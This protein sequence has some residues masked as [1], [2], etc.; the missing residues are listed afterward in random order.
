MTDQENPVTVNLK[1]PGWLQ[2]VVR[3]V[4]SRRP[5]FQN[6]QFVSTAREGL[7]AWKN[8]IDEGIPGED[9][10][11]AS[12]APA[13]LTFTDWP[14]RL[15]EVLALA[16]E[17]PDYSIVLGACEDGLP[18]TLDLT[19]P[20]PGSLLICGGAG[21]GMTHLLQSILVSATRLNPAYR[22]AFNLLAS[23]PGE[24]QGLGELDACQ[25][26]LPADGDAS[27]EVILELTDIAEQR[28][29][30]PLSGSILLLGIDD[31]VTCL[32]AI[33]ENTF[34]HLYWL[35]RHGPRSRVWTIATLPA[36]Q[37]DLVDVRFLSAFRT[38]LVGHI[39]KHE[40]PAL[41]PQAL[42]DQAAAL[43]NGWQFGVAKLD[44]WMSFWA[45]EPT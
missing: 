18:V 15:D 20:A 29:R 5:R 41:L 19:N 36:G 3:A 6:A 33:D 26:L 32:Q 24:Y 38:R 1:G 17:L 28:R 13:A 34:N 4:L 39:E 27:G 23:Q 7:R 10:G 31:L 8:R 30:E 35:I 45:C 9:G 22:V 14:P 12:M 42:A 16:G 21:S 11:P 40:Y 2:P 25:V 44:G 43:E 37:A